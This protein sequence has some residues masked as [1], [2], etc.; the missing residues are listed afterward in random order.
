MTI[1]NYSFIEIHTKEESIIRT[2]ASEEEMKE[3][4]K[5][6]KNIENY[7]WEDLEDLIVEKGFEIYPFEIDYSFDW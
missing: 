1:Y 3:I 4:V 2:N 5:E 7:T 6:F